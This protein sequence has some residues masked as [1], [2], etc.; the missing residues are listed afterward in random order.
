MTANEMH[1]EL[2]RVIAGVDGS[3]SA[4][5]AALWAAQEAETR[6]VP[7]SLVHAL[8][9]GEGVAPVVGGATEEEPRTRAGS[10]IVAS[11]AEVVRERHPALMVETELSPL[12]PTRQLTELSAPDTLVVTGTRGHGGFVGM[13]IGSVSRALAMHSRGPLVV[14][15]GPR[16]EQEAGPVILGVGAKP[17]EA[18]AEYAFAAAQRYGAPLHAVRARAA[19]PRVTP[20]VE[21]PAIMPSGLGLRNAEVPIGAQQAI[22]DDH[23]I[24]R[25]EA[26]VRQAIE[27]A[28]IRYPEVE[29]DVITIVADAAKLLAETGEDAR[30]VVVGSH[31]RHGPISMG[32][33]HV[34]EKLLAHSPAPVAVIPD[35]A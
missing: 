26:L 2:R 30:L 21:V 35:S 12:A 1:T 25:E 14:V 20:A 5:H 34:T 27:N 18:T 6:G 9:L 4:Q 3:D 8:D 7:L 16:A 28:R 10:R 31:H 15:R 33:G 23:L 22:E 19:Q 29:V 17:A 13:L 11:V 24:E 32:P